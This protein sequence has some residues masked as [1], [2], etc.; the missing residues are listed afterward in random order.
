MSLAETQELMATM[1]ELVALLS[2]VETKTAKLIAETP[3]IETAGTSFRQVERVALRYLTLARRMGL[4]NEVAQATQVISQLIIMIRMAE[5]SLNMLS[6]ATP[7][8][9]ALGAAGLLMTALSATDFMMSEG[10]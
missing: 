6:K 9:I 2:E 7:F 5:M 8:G 3:Q 1:K 4:P 10:G